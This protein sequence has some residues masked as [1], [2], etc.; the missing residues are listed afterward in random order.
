[1][2][3][4]LRSR[5]SVLYEMLE[6]AIGVIGVCESNDKKVANGQPMVIKH[7]TENY[8]LSNTNPTKNEDEL[9]CSERVNNSCSISC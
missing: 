5:I 2:R 6:D 9:W 4:P 1:M 7:Y 8:R 3:C